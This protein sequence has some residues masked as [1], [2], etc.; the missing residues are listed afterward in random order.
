MSRQI[1]QPINQVRLT[2]VAV[3][4][5][6]KDGKR[7]E[8]A[9]YRNKVIDYRQGLEQDLSEV[10][11]T[12][13]VFTNVSKGEFAKAKDLQKVFGT[14][15]EEEIAKLI[16][17][18]GQMQVSDK[19]RSQQLEKTT[20]QIAEWISKNCVHPDTDRPYTILQIKHGMK[21][22]AF[23]VHPTKPLKRQYLD[24]VKLL[25]QVMPIQRA[26]MELLLLVPTG[27]S[28]QQVE[29]ILKEHDVKFTPAASQQLAEADLVRY[30]VLVDPSLY[31]ILNDLLQSNIPGAKIEIVNQVVTKQGDYMLEEEVGNKN[32]NHDPN[33]D[34]VTEATSLLQQSKLSS[35]VKD[36]DD[37]E[38][39]DSASDEQPSSSSDEEDILQSMASRRKAQKKAK[40]K[41]QKTANRQLADDTAIKEESVS[42]TVASATTQ[43]VNDRISNNNNAT[44]TDS[45]NNNSDDRKSC[46]TCGG[47][48]ATPADF[49]AHFKSDWHR[50]NQKLKLKGAAPISEQE[51]LLVDA[52]IGNKQDG[53]DIL[54]L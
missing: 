18:K 34:P 46:N 8:I 32:N 41:N 25:Q 20:A 6:N 40:K 52:E 24:C 38:Q 12:D 47:S 35:D 27:N 9:C 42:G 31:R 29:D 17:A 49:R 23:S 48:F 21:H 53:D 22:A 4:R 10:L 36:N 45:N 44:S 39:D 26:K 37:D 28:I 5:M 43:P 33:F 2:N 51:F 11:Q 15:D 19:E 7:F 3:V 16:L 30:P 54:L 14:K 1:N 13:R 50:F